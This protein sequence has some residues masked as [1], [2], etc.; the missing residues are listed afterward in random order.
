MNRKLQ[1]YIEGERLELFQDEKITINSSIQNINDISKV[2]TDLTQSFTV[3]ATPHN[4]RIFHH[5]YNSDVDARNDVVL[6]YNIRRTAW[7]E[8]DLTPL[9]SGSIQLEKSNIKNGQP[10]SYTIVFY[11]QLTSLKD[12]FGE[13]QLSDL[14]YSS[15]SHNYTGAEVLDRITGV[16]DY[17]VRYPL[18]SSERLWQYG[19]GSQNIGNSSHRINFTELFPALKI[20]RIFD[21]IQTKYGI[22]IGGNIRL[23]KRFD[24]CFLFLKNKDVLNIT[25]SAVQVDI[26]F[27]TSQYFDSTTNEVLMRYIEPDSLGLAGTISN[28]NGNHFV[29]IDVVPSAS[30]TYY[31]DIYYNGQL[32]GTTTESGNATIDLGTLP[33]SYGLAQNVSVKFRSAPL[34]APMTFATTYNYVFNYSLLLNGS[35]FNGTINASSVNSTLTLVALIDLSTLV[36]E[37]KVADFVSGIIKEY[38]LTVIPESETSYK[39]E[40]VDNW[41]ALG[42][43]YDITE[44]TD[45]TSI[46]IERVKLYK[47]I[48]FKHIESESFMNKAFK[49]NNLREYGSLDYQFDTDGNDYTIDLPFEN[50]LFSRLANNLQVG[51]NLTKAPDYKPYI[52]KPTL[53]FLNDRVSCDTFYVNNGTN[54]IAVTGYFPFGQD[55]I[56]NATN[57]SLNFGNDISSFYEVNIPNSMFVTW[58]FNYLNN[59]FQRK[60][61]LTYVKTKLPLYILTQLKLNDRLIIRDRRYLINEMKIDLSNGVVDFV[62]LNDFAQLIPKNFSKKEAGSQTFEVPISFP[63]GAVN[64]T[65]DL[66]NANGATIDED[67]LINDG[68]I[69]ITAPAYKPKQLKLRVLSDGGTFEA[70][71][72]L[73]NT[74]PSTYIIG[75]KYNYPTYTTIENILIIEEW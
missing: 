69:T 52:P 45:V 39:L 33:N 29:T 5:F 40:S 72:C 73:T 74:F 30:T 50:L 22:T 1:I 57:Y 54:S 25:T 38:N 36:P 3:P 62:L 7:I 34:A 27:T 19:S 26:P 53:L 23:D 17:D 35:V 66:T 12:K 4:N 46:N 6:N 24:N 55:V 75:I 42:T 68:V 9:R 15:Y 47:K 31:V 18:I 60:N 70:Q 49:E 67:L 43:T 59:L 61:R 51:Y 37:M 56:S 2:F 14:D 20:N 28:F 21:A 13:D 44:F 65:F 71:T 10:Y 58:Y 11:G 8:I 16:T 41:Y 32:M 48:A 63:N 64:I